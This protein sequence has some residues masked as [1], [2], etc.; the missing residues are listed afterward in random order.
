MFFRKIIPIIA[1][2]FVF[3]NISLSE[4]KNASSTDTRKLV[5]SS[6]SSPA[7]LDEAV[8]KKRKEIVNEAVAAI[9]ETNKALVALEQN[10]TQ[11]ALNALQKAIGE[12]EVVLARD[13]NLAFAVIDTKI[14]VHDLYSSLES[15]DLARAQAEDYLRHSQIQKARE[16]LRDLAY[17]V[18]LSEVSIPLGTYPDILKDAVSLI[19]AGNTKGAKVALQV[20]LDSLV[21]TNHIIPLGVIRAEKELDIAE[22]LADKK[23]RTEVENSSLK[24]ALDKARFQLRM[25]EALGYG[26]TEDY[27]PIYKHL[28]DIENNATDTPEKSR[29]FDEIRKFFSDMTKPFYD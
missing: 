18:T 25:S 29:F 13:S 6:G 15:I 23:K 2:C 22:E 3:P 7:K 4:V 17:E 11:D 28:D 27:S 16:I 9:G 14:N 1:L 20:A 24:L 19:D 8:R 21:V 26:S 12:L 10:K 5:D